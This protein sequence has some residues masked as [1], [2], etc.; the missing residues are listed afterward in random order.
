[1]VSRRVVSVPSEERTTSKLSVMTRLQQVSSDAS[2]PCT[3]ALPGVNGHVPSTFSNQRMAA[4]PS[5]HV[6]WSTLRACRIPLRSSASCPN[7]PTSVSL[8]EK[9]SEN[10]GQSDL[11]VMMSW[12]SRRFA[13]L[14]LARERGIVV[15]V[16]G[17]TLLQCPL[18]PPVYF[19]YDVGWQAVELTG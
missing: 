4:S 7:F 1:M 3:K 19:L 2:R 12:S 10:C 8:L 11:L 15:A 14:E 17:S 13:E 5:L 9:R 16:P 18:Y 6:T